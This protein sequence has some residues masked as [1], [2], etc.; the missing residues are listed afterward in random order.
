MPVEVGT[1][2]GVY[3]VTGALGAG[4]MGEVY[5]AR[6]PRLGRNV[7]I[8]VLPSAFSHDAGR[9][10]RFEQEARAAAGLNHPNILA[11]YDIGQ[12]P[13]TPSTSSEQAVPYIV[14]ELLDG[15]TLL[16]LLSGTALPVRK[17][18]EYGAQIAKGLAAAHGKGI[19]HR[20]L[21]PANLFITT[22]GRVKILDFGLAK[23]TEKEPTSTGASDLAT[24]VNTDP[25][26][27]LGTVGYM[28][29]EQVRGLPAD[30]R[31]DIFAFGCVLYQ[32]L[33]GQ[34]AFRRDT[35][36]DTMT[37]ILKEDPLDLPL[38]ERHIPPA[39]ARIVDRCLEKSPGARFQSTGD[40]AFALEAISSHTDGVPVMTGA[41]E[42]RKRDR[43]AWTL[44][45]VLA[46]VVVIGLGLGTALFFGQHR[47]P[48]TRRASL[49]RRRTDGRW[50]RNWR[51]R[52]RWVRLPWPPM[53]ARWRSSP[54]TRPA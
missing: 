8:K 39:L 1:R 16:D 34:R 3:E 45:T 51:E 50:P 47:R 26:L 44:V 31:S 33:S 15:E 14:S 52:R 43:L 21:K 29:P 38:A 36:I 30:H 17:A 40:L 49:F 35:S 10:A 54:E 7:A 32:M 41:P 12:L 28:A 37:A 11:V 53:A 9:L 23:L 5:R 13:S 4:G 20:D 18:T 48:A 42:P 24:K 22:D 27:L 19:V 6:D 46:V 25:G 2:L